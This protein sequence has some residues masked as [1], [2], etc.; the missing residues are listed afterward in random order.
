MKKAD[1][2]IGIDPDVDLSGVAWLHPK[3]RILETYKMD[4]PEL[5]CYLS[6]AKTIYE[7]KYYKVSIV[8]E[9]SWG[10]SHNYHL[11]EMHIEDKKKEKR[12]AAKTG[13][14]VGRNHQVGI[15]ICKYARSIG[16]DVIEHTPLRKGWKGCNG[17]ITHV[18]LKYFTGIEGKTNQ[19][20]RDAALLA[21]NYAG[22]PIRVKV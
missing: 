9:A 13:Y 2:I 12:I 19:E 22:L 14:N 8:V 6:K 5:L 15:D 4:L 17:K 11:N 21:W 1:I 18:E 20:E 7:E 10:N 3:T 16:F